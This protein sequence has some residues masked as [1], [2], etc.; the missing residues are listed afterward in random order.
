MLDEMVGRLHHD[1]EP[2]VIGDVPAIAERLIVAPCAGRFVP[3]PVDELN[4]EGEWVEP[5]R[6]VGEIAAGRERVAVRSSFRGWLAGC[7]ALPGAPVAAGEA[8]FC[9]RSC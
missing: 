9:V 6:V 7:L 1:V 4:P 8:L 3:L 5:G 2:E